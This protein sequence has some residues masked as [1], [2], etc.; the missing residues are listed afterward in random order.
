[1]TK[2]LIKFNICMFIYE[3]EQNILYNL[4]VNIYIFMDYEE[5]V[6]YFRLHK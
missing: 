2:K 5:M 4:Q 6:V 1:M 3:R